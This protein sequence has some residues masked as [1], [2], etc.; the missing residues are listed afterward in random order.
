MKKIN[1]IKG[2]AKSECANFNYEDNFCYPRDAKCYFFIDVDENSTLS[3]CKYFENSVLPIDPGLEYEYRREREL[4][5]AEDIDR[6]DIC[7]AIIRKT[8][9][10]KKYCDKCKKKVNRSQ[11]R[12][13]VQK[14][15][16]M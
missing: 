14:M 9:N 5:I 15:R 10:R 13:R 16:G 2:L 12:S 8:S 11:T 6:C 1:K 3:R 7:G 4:G